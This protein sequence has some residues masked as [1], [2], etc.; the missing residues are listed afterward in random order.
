MSIITP[1]EYQIIKEE[2][3]RALTKQS[4]CDCFK[5]GNVLRSNQKF[6]IVKI[7]DDYGSPLFITQHLNCK[8]PTIDSRDVTMDW[9]EMKNGNKYKAMSLELTFSGKK[10]GASMEPI[11]PNELIKGKQS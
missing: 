9:N 8:D 4:S 1:E 3:I 5:C 10:Q 6:E 2:I 7:H 11:D